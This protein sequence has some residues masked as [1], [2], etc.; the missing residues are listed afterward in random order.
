MFEAIGAIKWALPV[1]R[2]L[3]KNRHEVMS[4]WEKF[5][6]RLLGPKSSIAFVG[7]GGIGKTV[8]LDHITGAANKV[9]YKHPGQ[10]R[11]QEKG[12]AKADGNRM[13]IV[14]AP[15]QGGPRVDS[16]DEIFDEKKGVDGL[17]FVAGSGL[18]SLRNS[19]AIQQNIKTGLDTVEKWRGVNL[20]AELEDLKEVA[21]HIRAS[22]KKSRKPKW[23]LVV[24]TKA[25]LLFENLT[26]IE[27]YYSPHGGSEFASV[28]NELMDNLGKDNFEWD[29]LPAC[30]AL[31]DFHWGD[32]VVK[33]ALDSDARDH[34]LAQMVSKLGELCR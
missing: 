16:F 28:L 3:Y 31:E 11:R 19:E 14:V 22:S 20:A 30:S 29:A 33:S 34:Y 27:Q 24:A 26:E 5:V 7:P 10:S 9:D 17:V 4:G 2:D 21:A 8:L 32:Q 25:D 18:V 15:G 6:A 23:M 12:K 1:S 13:A